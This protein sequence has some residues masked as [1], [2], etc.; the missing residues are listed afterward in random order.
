[1]KCHYSWIWTQNGNHTPE[2]VQHTILLK[3]FLFLL[4]VFLLL[5]KH[6]MHRDGRFTSSI[7]IAS[8]HI[9]CD[10]QD[11]SVWLITICVTLSSIQ[12]CIQEHELIQWCQN[13][14]LT[15]R[16][17]QQL[18]LTMGRGGNCHRKNR[19]FGRNKQNFLWGKKCT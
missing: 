13:G 19:S 16:N 9:Y 4:K 5:S 14:L 10:C 12:R 6:F 17:G 7:E 3:I 8:I 15:A 18:Y 11:Y 2:F 1:M